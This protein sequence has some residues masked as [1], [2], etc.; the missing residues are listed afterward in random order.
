MKY[1]LPLIL[2][3]CATHHTSESIRSS[4]LW[5]QFLLLGKGS[6]C[7]FPNWKASQTSCF[8]TLNFSKPN[9]I[10]FSCNFWS[11]WK[12]TW[13]IRLCHKSMSEQIL[14]LLHFLLGCNSSSH[15]RANIR[16]S[17]NPKICS[18]FCPASLSEEHHPCLCPC[19]CSAL[20]W[21]PATDL[22]Q[23]AT[24]TTKDASQPSHSDTM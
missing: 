15:A 2:T 14:E 10:Y 3:F 24:S 5:I 17:C 22:C 23:K 9:M 8:G 6:R 19:F 12:L 11:L 1:R 20:F 13:P 21:N 18:C 16:A 7:Y 4:L